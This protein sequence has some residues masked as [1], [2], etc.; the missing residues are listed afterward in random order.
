MLHANLEQ[1][2]RLVKWP[3]DDN[4]TLV[5][6]SVSTPR[7]MLQTTSAYTIPELGSET[8][9]PNLKALRWLLHSPPNDIKTRIVVG[10]TSFNSK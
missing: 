10:R 3:E 6:N 1:T 5:I 4:R 7:D 2:C 9:K 8:M